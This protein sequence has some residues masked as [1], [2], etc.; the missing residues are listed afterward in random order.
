M[1]RLIEHFFINLFFMIDFFFQ[2]I[3]SGILFSE[4]ICQNLLR[5]G[6]IGLK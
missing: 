1:T 6:N 2:G 5:R 4:K 3:T